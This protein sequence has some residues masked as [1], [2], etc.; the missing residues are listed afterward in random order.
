MGASSEENKCKQTEQECD[1]LK[2]H[3]DED[4]GLHVYQLMLD[5]VENPQMESWNAY[6]VGIV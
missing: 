5:S 6:I 3:Y 1:G 4:Q 2:E